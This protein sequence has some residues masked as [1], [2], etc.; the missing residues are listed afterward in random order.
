MP[1]PEQNDDDLRA[2]IAAMQQQLEAMQAASA[3]SAPPWLETM[4]A[5]VTKASG[6]ASELLASK[7]KPENADH[8]HLGPFEHKEGGIK[9]PKEY[10]HADGHVS[11]FHRAEIVYAGRILRAE[12]VT[13]LEWQAVNELSESLG[14]AQR[15][16]A[17]DGTWAAT[18][19]DQDTRLQL[20]VPMKTMDDR[21]NLPPFLLICQELTSGARQ[22]DQAE[23]ATEVAS[24]R[25]ELARLSRLILAGAAA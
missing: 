3:A 21:Q 23:L 20:S 19:N 13:Y 25:E 24:L 14:R 7:L 22:K 17:R 4:L 10:R 15:R 18:V 1:K 8:L 2:T 16:I 6:Q 9:F 12:E 11:D 5:R